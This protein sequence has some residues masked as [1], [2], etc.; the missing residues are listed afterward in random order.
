MKN[1]L[2]SIL[3]PV[4]FNNKPDTERDFKRQKNIVSKQVQMHLSSY[5][6]LRKII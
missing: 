3:L 2:N 4:L 5:A 6:Y 1:I